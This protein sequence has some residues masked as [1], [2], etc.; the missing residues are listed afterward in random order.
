MKDF[1]IAFTQLIPW[2]KCTWISQITGEI[3]L[4]LLRYETYSSKPRA[5]NPRR[6][7]FKLFELVAV[8]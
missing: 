8:V 3:W 1:S 7:F 5:T 2:V 4:H 6:E